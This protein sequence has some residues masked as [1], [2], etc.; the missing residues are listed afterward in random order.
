M[1]TLIGDKTQQI[2]KYRL[3]SDR[4]NY[5]SRNVNAANY[6]KNSLRLGTTGLDD[7]PL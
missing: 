3:C 1:L 5:Q 4:Q 2:R 6:R 7:D